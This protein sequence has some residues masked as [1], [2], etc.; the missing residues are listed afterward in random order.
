VPDI[1]VGENIIA[2][3]ERQIPVIPNAPRGIV[4]VTKGGRTAKVAEPEYGSNVVVDP[5]AERRAEAKRQGFDG[6]KKAMEK[7]AAK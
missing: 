2:F 3:G 5:F 7:A 6:L 1:N 4:S